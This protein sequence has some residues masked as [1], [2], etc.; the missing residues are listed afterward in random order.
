MAQLAAQPQCNHDVKGGGAA[1]QRQR[2]FRGYGL[3]IVK[4]LGGHHAETFLV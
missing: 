3:V 1:P 4:Q 2:R